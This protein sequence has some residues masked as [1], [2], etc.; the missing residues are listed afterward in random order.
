MG[1]SG[2]GKT[3]V[4]QLLANTLGW[5]FYDGDDFHPPGNIDKM[6]RG[7]P[8]DDADRIPWLQVLRGAIEGWLQENKNVVMACSFAE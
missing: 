3:T 2:T 7:I 6:Q 8:L 1:V 5:E 4:G